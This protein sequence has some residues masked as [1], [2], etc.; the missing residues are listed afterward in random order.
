MKK[1]FFALAAMLVVSLAAPA[2]AT[3]WGLGAGGFAGG[4]TGFGQ[5]SS[6]AGNL[7][8][9]F[10]FGHSTASAESQSFGRAESAFGVGVGTLPDG[11]DGTPGGPASAAYGNF[12]GASVGSGSLSNAATS[13]TGNG[14]SGAGTIGSGFGTTTLGGVGVGVGGFVTSGN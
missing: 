8:G 7:S 9:S 12:V 2:S 11:A 5:S 3:D 10:K 14:F 13:S 1:M 4:L 6:G